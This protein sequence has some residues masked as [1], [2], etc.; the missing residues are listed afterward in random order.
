MS[1]YD[2]EEDDAGVHDDKTL[3]C[4]HEIW[5]V[6]AGALISPVL[7]VSSEL[8]AVKSTSFTGGEGMPFGGRLRSIQRYHT[9][10]SDLKRLVID[11][12]AL[13]RVIH[14]N[15]CQSAWKWGFY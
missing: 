2:G 4:C 13:H 15:R 6:L 8:A 10:L 7:C 5:A 9:E 12:I 14:P 11:Q 1:Y 3:Y